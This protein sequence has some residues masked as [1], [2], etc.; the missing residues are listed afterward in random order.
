MVGQRPERQMVKQPA[1]RLPARR[2][3]RTSPELTAR[4]NKKVNTPQEKSKNVLKKK[5]PF[6]R[7][8]EQAQQPEDI[9][10]GAERRAEGAGKQG[11][12][13]AVQTA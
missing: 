11:K 9:V 12:R 1:D 8:D 7:I 10:I 6:A 4:A 3:K 5:L 13:Q 2:K